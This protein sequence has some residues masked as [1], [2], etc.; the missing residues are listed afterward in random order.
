M[1][2]FESQ[3]DIRSRMDEEATERAYAEL[4]SS[5]LD[6]K[7][8]IVYQTDDLEALDRAVSLCLQYNHIEPGTVPNEIRR[9]AKSLS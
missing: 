3:I 9:S 1:G 6:P 4:A 5:I 8:R 7:H 2:F